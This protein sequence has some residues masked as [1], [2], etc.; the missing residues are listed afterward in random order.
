VKRLENFGQTHDIFNQK[1]TEKW[2]DTFQQFKTNI[3]QI[4]SAVETLIDKTFS[5]K[6]LN[7]SEGAFDLLSKF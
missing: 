1:Y 4:D 5:G 3:I 6:Q 2:K 7:S